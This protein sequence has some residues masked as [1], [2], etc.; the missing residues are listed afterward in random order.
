MLEISPRW[1]MVE[2][3]MMD[4]LLGFMSTRE[5]S[6]FDPLRDEGISTPFKGGVSN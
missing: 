2:M 4:E 3:G 1:W 6:I 5:R